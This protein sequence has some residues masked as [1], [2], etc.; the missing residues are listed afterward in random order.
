MSQT[1]SIPQDVAAEEHGSELMYCTGFH[2]LYSQNIG[3]RQNLELFQRMRVVDD[4]RPHISS[5]E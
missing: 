4:S 2:D 5:N 3:D 1:R